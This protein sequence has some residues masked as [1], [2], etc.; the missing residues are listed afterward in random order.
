VWT[1]LFLDV[2]ATPRVSSALNMPGAHTNARRGR[3]VTCTAYAFQAGGDACSL[4]LP[5]TRSA[6]TR[7]PAH[8]PDRFSTCPPPPHPPPYTMARVRCAYALLTPRDTTIMV[9]RWAPSQKVRHYIHA[10]GWFVDKHAGDHTARTDCRRRLRCTLRIPLPS[11]TPH[12]CLWHR[13][14]APAHAPT[15]PHPTHTLPHCHATLSPHH[16]PHTP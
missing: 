12:I 10:D 2:S 8:S 1:A 15:P 16:T 11:S 7:L 14:R 13:H 9:W 5:D 3:D 6:F 4:A